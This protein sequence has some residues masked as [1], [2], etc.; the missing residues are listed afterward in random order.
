MRQRYVNLKKEG[1]RR[2][3]KRMEKGKDKQTY[4]ETNTHKKKEEKGTPQ[5]HRGADEVVRES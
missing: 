3:E 2:R 1:W 4:K 5:T